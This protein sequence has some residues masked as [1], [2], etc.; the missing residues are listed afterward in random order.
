MLKHQIHFSFINSELASQQWL[1]NTIAAYKDF[2]GEGRG[3]WI[4]DKNDEQEKPCHTINRRSRRNEEAKALDIVKH[5]RLLQI[6]VHCP[7]I[8]ARL[9][10][11]LRLVPTDTKSVYHNS[12][13]F[14]YLLVNSPDYRMFIIRFI[15]TGDSE[16]SSSLLIDSHE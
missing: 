7:K 15:K 14:I 13:F 16:E 3:R 4:T 5:K 11:E 10:V 12:F 8:F 2:G 1:F 6:N 9:H